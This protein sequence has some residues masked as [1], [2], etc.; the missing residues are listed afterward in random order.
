MTAKETKL[1]EYLEKLGAKESVPGGGGASALAGAYGVSLGLMVVSFTSGKKKYAEFEPRLTIIKDRL[2]K[3]RTRFLELSDE[4]E[5]VFYPLSRAYGLP[6]G[7]VEEK[8]YKETTLE[9]CLSAASMTPIK[10]ME[11]VC[12]ALNYMQELADNGSKL[13]LSDVGVGVSFLDTALQGAV[14]NVYINT[15]MM[16]NR[17]RMIELNEYAY[18]LL[19][20][21]KSRSRLIYEGVEES[22]RPDY[23]AEKDRIARNKVDFS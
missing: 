8:D 2:E 11:C 19:T 20:D 12:E 4:D 23:D 7:T 5:K 1:N 17:N 22:L 3:L 13:M 10:V 16:K 14:M 9:S 15:K 18:K 21:G 6:E